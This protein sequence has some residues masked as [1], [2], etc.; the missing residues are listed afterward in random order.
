LG[1]E[2]DFVKEN[3]R[4]DVADLQVFKGRRR[5][6]WVG[7]D[8]LGVGGSWVFENV[9]FYFNYTLKSL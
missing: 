5:W 2:E 3:E 1:G 4:K 9:R 8:T 7:G 6:V